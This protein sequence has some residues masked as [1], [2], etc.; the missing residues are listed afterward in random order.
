MDEKTGTDEVPL[1]RLARVYRRISSEMQRITAEYETAHEA[2][3]AQREAVRLA[4][5]DRLLGMGVNS[6]STAHGTVILSTQT[7]YHTQDWDGFKRFIVEQDALD[8]LEKRISQSNMAQFL[9]QN[10]SLVPPGLNSHAEYVI[11]VRKPRS[12]K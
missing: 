3:K 10:P 7:R 2:L 6:A 5:K 12:S 1:D 9:Q 4:L 11:S 8:L